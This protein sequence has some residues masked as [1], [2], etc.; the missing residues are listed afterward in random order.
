MAAALALVLAGC[1]SGADQRFA[2]AVV[3]PA[4]V[5]ERVSAPGAV[6]AAA[7]A[8][9][10]APAA[11]KIQA[12]RVTDGATVRHG[13]VLAQLSSGQVDAAIR[14]AQ[15]ALGSASSLGGVIPSLPTGAALTTLG[16]LQQQ[17]S[18]SSGAVLDALRATLPLL[19]Q[20]QRARVQASLDQ[21]AQR[22]AAAQQAASE[23]AQQAAAA[24]NQQ[25][26]ALRN[27]IGAATAAQRS[28][29]QLA[30]DLANQQKAAL[31]LR[32]PLS[33]TVQ[34]GRSSTAPAGSV[35]GLP[36]VSSLPESAQQALQSLA[37]GSG[38]G[39]SGPPLRAGSQVSA[40]Q[41]VAT[42]YEVSTLMVAAQ[43]DETDIP[44][45]RVGQEADVELDAFP[46][47]SF[48]AR[49]SRVSVA[50]AQGQS[51]AGGAAYEVDLAIGRLEAS[52]GPAGGGGPVP[53][54][55]MTATAEIHVR[56]AVDAPAVPTSAMIEQGRGQAIYVIEG[57]RVH[58]RAVTVA[59]EG[60]DQVAVASGVR[61]GERVVSRG[62]E[63]L[64]DGQSWHGS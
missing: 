6:Q 59:A 15:A 2:S 26:A 13:Q 56:R 20:A 41:T 4:T 30:L 39:S 38:G 53:R 1:G 10:V 19:P 32:A 11:A 17:V 3:Q 58:L 18:S 57:G 12:L 7:M 45:V 55:G 37:G 35:A 61:N 24:V 25:T 27:A 50:P 23:A 8:D 47:A 44:L 31:T 21:A 5:V 36:S 51:A 28:Q 60:E 16:Q 29:A 40:G 63:R 46:G 33:G 42:V 9:L 48:F 22:I 43:V 49:V 62:A 64:H 14:Q 52:G 34:L 54:V